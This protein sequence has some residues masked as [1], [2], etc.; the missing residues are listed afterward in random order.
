M[1]ASMIHL[2]ID[3]IEGESQDKDHS[4]EINVLSYSFGISNSASLTGGGWGTG[5]SS[6]SDFSFSMYKGKSSAKLLEKCN[7]GEHI[8]TVTLKL[9]KTTGA[10]NPEVFEET[11]FKDVV[12]S[13]VS[14]GGAGEGD[15]IESIS[16]AFAAIEVDY[17]MQKTEGGSLESASTTTWDYKLNAKA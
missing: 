15:P 14:T 2:L 13:S 8:P 3:G 17:K 1:A 5:K 11:K 6:P 4:N 12:V 16:L 7:N 10:D 9:S